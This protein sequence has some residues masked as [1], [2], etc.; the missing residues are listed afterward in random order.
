MRVCTCLCV[1]SLPL[2]PSHRPTGAY[3]Y[4]QEPNHITLTWIEI[5]IYKVEVTL[6]VIVLSSHHM[7]TKYILNVPIL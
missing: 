2:L 1:F 6:Q 7:F 5:I 3:L 4:V